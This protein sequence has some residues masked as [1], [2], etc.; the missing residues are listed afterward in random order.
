MLP[1][2]MSC[3][4]QYHQDT[5]TGRIRW[6]C[7]CL[8][9]RVQLRTCLIINKHL[10][11]QDTGLSPHYDSL[12]ACLHHFQKVVKVL[13]LQLTHVDSVMKYI[14]QNICVISIEQLV[15]RMVERFL[16]CSFKQWSS[17][18]KDKCTKS[19]GQFVILDFIWGNFL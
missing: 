13:N 14:Y 3:I 7:R 9:C 8:H 11:T 2:P 12:K 6:L 4:T 5:P 19:K 15:I 17:V 18:N 16:K 1:T 10:C